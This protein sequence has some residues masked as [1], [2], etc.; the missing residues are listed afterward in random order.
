[1]KLNVYEL[2]EKYQIWDKV[3][4]SIKKGFDSEA[5]YNEKW[6]ETKVKSYEGKISTHFHDHGI[7]KDCAHCICLSVILIDSI[8]KIGRNCYPEVYLEEWK[9]IVKEKSN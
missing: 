8:F 3:S 1:M 7:T 5:V 9:N 2:L 4:K 6:L